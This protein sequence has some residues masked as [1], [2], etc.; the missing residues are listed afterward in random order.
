[1]KPISNE[2]R[3]L[4]IE[5]K[6]RG[7]K[8]GVIA[9]WLKISKRSVGTIWKL[10]RD[11]SGFQPAKYAGRKSRLGD[12]KIGGICSA[13]SENPDITLNELIERLSLPIKKSQLSKLLIK[14]GFSYKKRLSTRKNSSGMMSKKNV[15]IGRASKRH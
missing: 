4:I 2:K 7:E 3:E 14:L 10:F 6:Q 15:P 13:I 1:M 12:E 9:V 5:A 8:E 11:T